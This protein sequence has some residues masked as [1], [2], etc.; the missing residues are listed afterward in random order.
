MPEW[1]SPLAATVRSLYLREMGSGP[2]YRP[3]EPPQFIPW[4]ERYVTNT[5]ADLQRGAEISRRMPQ[6]L[7]G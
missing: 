1:S 2:S 3:G 7:N 4:L 6:F 5:A